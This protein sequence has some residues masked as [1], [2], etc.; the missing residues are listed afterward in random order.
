MT[1]ATR[2]SDYAAGVEGTLSRQAALVK[3]GLKGPGLN[4]LART[5]GLEW[6]SAVNAFAGVGDRGVLARVGRDEIILEC[7]PNHSMLAS[8]ER[9]FV[10]PLPD[11]YRI[12]QQSDTFELG[13]EQALPVF[14]QTCGVNIAAEPAGRLVQTR[15]AG[16]SCVIFPLARSGERVYRIWVDCTLAPYLWEQLVISCSPPN[17]GSHA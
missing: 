16:V 1:S 10:A 11:V 3:L 9:S 12:E 13:G 5:L 2:P 17:D 8:I 6:P 15:V 14:A 4:D 7:E